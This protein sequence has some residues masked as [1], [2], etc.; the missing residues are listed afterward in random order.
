MRWTR[1][2]PV[3]RMAALDRWDGKFRAITGAEWLS[4]TWG[5]AHQRM[6]PRGADTALR[7]APQIQHAE[8]F[9]ICEY[10]RRASRQEL[11]EI[12]PR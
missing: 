1:M 8:A 9:Q 10:G 6:R 12:F 4:K 3:L 11:D 2:L 5:R 7:A